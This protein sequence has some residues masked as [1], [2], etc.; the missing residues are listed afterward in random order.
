[1]IENENAKFENTLQFF[2]HIG[3]IHYK[4]IRRTGLAR[5]LLNI[6]QEIRKGFLRD[7]REVTLKLLFVAKLFETGI[8]CVKGTVAVL[9]CMCRKTHI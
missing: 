4:F 9:S 2:N 1:M 6:K 8:A 3:P 7:L 5:K